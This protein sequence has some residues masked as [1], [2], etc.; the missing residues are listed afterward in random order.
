M[1]KAQ[2]VA[3]LFSVYIVISKLCINAL[4]CEMEV[5]SVL[6]AYLQPT[7]NNRRKAKKLIT[8]D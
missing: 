4:I 7:S 6:A 8:S 3:S 1:S 5:F 2:E